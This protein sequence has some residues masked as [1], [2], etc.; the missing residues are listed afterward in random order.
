[1]R[2]RS[3]QAGAA[4]PQADVEILRDGELGE[5][6]W[7]LELAADA[8]AAQRIGRG[9]GA[10]PAEDPYLPAAHRHLPRHRVE[11]GGL[12]GAVRPDQAVD[13]G[14]VDRQVETFEDA[15]RSHADA[16]VVE[17]EA[18]LGRCRRPVRAVAAAP[19]GAAPKALEPGLDEA[20]QPLAEIQHDDDE[21][22][23]ED[24][25][26]VGNLVPQIGGQDANQD[27]ARDRAVQRRPPAD[28]GPDH[29]IGGQDEAAELRRDET[30]LGCVERPADPGER[31]A[32]AEHGGLRVLHREAAEPH[33]LLVLRDRPPQNPRRRAAQPGD[34]EHAG[35][36]SRGG[37]VVEVDKIAETRQGR[38]CS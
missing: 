9:A 36:E 7:R 38:E 30:L 4:A 19:R 8:D 13:A 1:M 12:A 27:G 37:D 23:R 34:A 24:D 33:P 20:H 31:A 6:A 21:N 32:D 26:P 2:R 5:Q 10:V 16:N 11:A 22:R 17:R 3:G 15:H 14:P 28:G 35:G 18:H 25:L 29:Q